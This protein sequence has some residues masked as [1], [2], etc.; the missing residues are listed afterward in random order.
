MDGKAESIIFLAVGLEETLCKGRKGRNQ[1][2]K[3]CAIDIGKFY[4][5]PRGWT[6][7]SMF[8]LTCVLV[9]HLRS[10]S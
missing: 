4:D 1:L 10:L 8:T 5:Y 6:V 2:A 9:S 3:R 7:P